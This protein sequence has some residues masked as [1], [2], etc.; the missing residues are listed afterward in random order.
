MDI[1]IVKL[2]ATDANKLFDFEM[3]NR[4]F[5]EEMVSTRGDDY[6]NFKIFKERH[7]TLL[8]EQTQGISLFYL[9]KDKRGSI[10]GRMNLVKVLEK[11][12]FTYV[13]TSDEE[14]EMNGQKFRFIYYTW[15]K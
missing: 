14:F 4:V 2:R 13:E 8:D 12:G 7:D 1:S 15:C 6:Y 11:N 9:I 10:L 5:F 3:E